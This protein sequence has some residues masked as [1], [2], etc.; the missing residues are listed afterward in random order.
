MVY[1]VDRVDA[2]SL[3]L[4]EMDGRPEVPRADRDLA[5]S[6]GKVVGDTF[7][8]MIAKVRESPKPRHL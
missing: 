7:M 6:R 3:D 2:K 1:F 4:C 5:R 8:A